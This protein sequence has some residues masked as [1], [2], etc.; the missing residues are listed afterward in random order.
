MAKPLN[1]LLI[2]DMEDDALLVLRALK[3]GGYK[4]SHTRVDTAEA[5]LSALEERSWDLVISDYNM[6]GFSGLE[7]LKLVL[8]SG[9]DLPFILISGAIGE[10]LAVQAML[11]GAQDYVMKERLQRLVPAVDR[12]LREVA[13]RREE[14]QARDALKISEEKFKNI[15]AA[16]P[17]GMHL[18]RLEPDGRLI[19]IGANQA[20]DTILGVPHKDFIGKTI[21]EAFPPLAES[22]IPHRY[23]MAARDGISWKT[24][25]VIYEDDRISGAFEVHAFQTSQNHMAAMF[26]DITDRIKAEARHRLVA[27]ILERLNQKGETHTIVRDIMKLIKAYTNVEAVGVRLKDGEDFPYIETNGLSENFVEKERFLCSRDLDGALLR[28]EQ[29][30]PVLECMCGNVI[31]GR[32]DPARSFFTEYGS[33]WSNSTTALLAGTTEEERQSAT[34]NRCNGAGY[35]SVA[36]IPL[37]S[38]DEIIGLLQLNDRRKDRFTEELITF[39]EGIGTSIGVAIA[40]VDAEKTLKETNEHLLATLDA[41]P[42]ILFEVDQGLCI[43]DFR[44]PDHSLLYVPPEQ[45]IGKSIFDVLPKEVARIISTA[46]ERAEVNGRSNS[47]TYFLDMPAGRRWFELSIAKKGEREESTSSRFIVL[48]RDITDR[49]SAEEG[50]EKLEEQLRQSQKM[51]AIGR[52]AG[53]VAHDFNNLLT[54]IK[55][56]A[57]FVY[58][59]LERGDERRGDVREIINAADSAATLTHQLLAFSRRQVVSPETVNLNKAVAK[60]EKMLRRIIGERIDLLFVPGGDIWRT[61]I[62]PGQID[63]ILVNLAVNAGDAIA[64]TGKLTIE[65]KNISL[66]SQLIHCCPEALSGDFIMLAVSDS[67]SGMSPATI[68]NIFEPFFTTKQ[69]GEGTGL[70]LSTIHGI[71][72]QN[73]GHIQV[74][75]EVGVGST[76][77][78]FLPRKLEETEPMGEAA[79]QIDTAGTELIFLIED[80]ETVR[81]LA[82]KVLVRKGY[83]VIDAGSA[84]QA[85]ALAEKMEGVVDLLLT[86]VVLPK[87]NGKDLYAEIEK[88]IT[89]TRVLYMSG[90]AENAITHH[91]VLETGTH[92]IQKPFRPQELAE[93]VREV[94]DSE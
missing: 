29:G 46:L 42:D 54:A 90:Y 53:G 43:L 50:R 14:L 77:K 23:R 89:V 51:E 19:F 17:N 70:G 12:E 37:R 57:D 49:K 69:Q 80:Q 10:E 91:G 6:P 52:L 44:A 93:K 33:F 84:E 82:R 3:K 65:T 73:G 18:Y 7:A 5:L 79:P 28:D 83:R 31:R 1:L 74:Y 88:R 60:S 48:A 58:E 35:E 78:I 56:F 47:A 8:K 66:D 86:D 15:I 67:G 76:F 25:Q 63:Q 20:A 21:G 39:F 38:D 34:R 55:G 64:D 68:K 92:F 4:P 75:S 16:T 71:V 9:R 24:E 45:F 26:V 94:L 36:L 32:T 72:H 2:E 61:R 40:Q 22:E 87:M 30:L 13:I 27:R 59:S 62:D 41:L 85:L 81:K 11:S